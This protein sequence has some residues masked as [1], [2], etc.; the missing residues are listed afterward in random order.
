MAANLGAGTT[1]VHLRRD[2]GDSGSEHEERC[3]IPKIPGSKAKG[4]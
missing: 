1:V 4:I 3:K 2:S